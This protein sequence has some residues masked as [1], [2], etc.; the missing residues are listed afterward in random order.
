MHKFHHTPDRISYSS[1]LFCKTNQVERM[2]YWW[3]IGKG[4]AFR[5]E[6]NECVIEAELQK[7]HIV[8]R[9]MVR[10]SVRFYGRHSLFFCW[11]TESIFSFFWLLHF[12]LE[13]R[14]DWKWEGLL[15]ENLLCKI[16]FHLS[17]LPSLFLHHLLRCI[18]K[19]ALSPVYL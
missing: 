12:L 3:K 14:I 1:I 19:L 2:N 11:V 15:N 8:P 10:L 5:E 7:A 16:S 18:S 13:I 17:S 9:R 6:I 4:E